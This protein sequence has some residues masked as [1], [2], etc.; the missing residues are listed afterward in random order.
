MRMKSVSSAD[1][2]VES[3]ESD[4]EEETVGKPPAVNHELSLVDRSETVLVQPDYQGR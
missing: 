4:L 2:S 1:S 3:A